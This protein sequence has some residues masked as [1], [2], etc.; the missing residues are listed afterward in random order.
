MKAESLY[1][2]LWPFRSMVTLTIQ[3]PYL[4]VP[5]PFTRCFQCCL[6]GVKDTSDSVDKLFFIY[7]VF[8]MCV[9]ACVLHV[10]LGLQRSEESVGSFGA[11]VPG[12]V[13]VCKRST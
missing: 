4:Y 13:G 3:I 12:T 9:R 5:P 1:P 2:L 6:S 11:E 10:C 7:L 8:K